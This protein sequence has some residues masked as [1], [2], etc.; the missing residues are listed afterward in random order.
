MNTI[1][2]NCVEPMPPKGQ[3]QPSKGQIWF[4]FSL[5]KDMFMSPRALITGEDR[6]SKT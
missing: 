5:V 2:K 6:I 3:I 1:K 4:D